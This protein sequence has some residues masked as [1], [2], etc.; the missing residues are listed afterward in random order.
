MDSVD[1]LLLAFLGAMIFCMVVQF[2]EDFRLFVHVGGKLTD[3]RSVVDL[4]F[5]V[6]GGGSVD[7]RLVDLLGHSDDDGVDGRGSVE[8]REILFHGGP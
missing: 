4:W 2:L 8:R 1:P 5:L 7:K 3:I 6:R